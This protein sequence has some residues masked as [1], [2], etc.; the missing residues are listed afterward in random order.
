VTL[1]K[2]V[3]PTNAKRPLRLTSFNFF[4]KKLRVDLATPIFFKFRVDLY[5]ANEKNVTFTDVF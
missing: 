5:D 4:K 3:S 1:C 2:H